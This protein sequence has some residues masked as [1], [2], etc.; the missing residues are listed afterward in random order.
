MS[1]PSQGPHQ[2]ASKAGLGVPIASSGEIELL[3]T[4][5][6]FT[7]GRVTVDFEADTTPYAFTCYP[8][9]V[10]LLSADESTVID[11]HFEGRVYG[12]CYHRWQMSG[13]LPEGVD[14]AVLR[15][16]WADDFRGWFQ[17]PPSFEKAIGD[18]KTG[19]PPPSLTSDV[20]PLVKTEE[21]RE[22]GIYEEETEPAVGAVADFGQ[23]VGDT[24][25]D[26][27]LFTALIAGGGALL[28]Y[29]GPIFTALSE[30]A[31]GQIEGDG[32]QEEEES[33]EEDSGRENP[34]SGGPSEKAP[35]K[36]GP[37]SR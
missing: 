5:T 25:R 29:G 23:E 33:G 28:W 24:V 7:S 4:G 32:D 2:S 30:Q 18:P 26:I 34:G 31:A 21:G 9:Y 22:Q 17:S 13:P 1:R 36:V 37:L 14:S 11:T 19:S 15:L 27:A 8:F 3:V 16:W 12:T 20:F 35:P 6:S 10:A